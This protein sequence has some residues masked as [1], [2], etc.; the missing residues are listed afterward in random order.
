MQIQYSAATQ[1]RR[2]RAGG[3]KK[4]ESWKLVPMTTGGQQQQQQSGTYDAG[5]H[6]S[7]DRKCSDQ[8]RCTGV[9]GAVT[10]RYCPLLS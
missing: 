6:L 10:F 8:K 7:Y 9:T 3:K 1:V 2:L 5:G 4:L